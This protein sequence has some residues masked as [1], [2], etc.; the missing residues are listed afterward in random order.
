M[1]LLSTINWSN[2]ITRIFPPEMRSVSLKAFMIS[3]MYPLQ[4]TV[5]DNLVFED[6]IRRRA[7]YNSQK[8]VLQDALNVIFTLTANTIVVE[9]SQN[10]S[11]NNYIYNESEGLTLFSFNETE[12]NSPLFCFNESE[13][14]DPF[15]FLIKVPI[16][17]Y[18]SELDRRI[19]AEV[20]TYKLAGKSFNVVTY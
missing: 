12:S 10:L 5:T 6:E 15:D 1:S 9:G 3:L 8:I 7:R 16:G 17:I 18:T 14:V 4:N 13:T 20:K 2:V 19:R 11:Y